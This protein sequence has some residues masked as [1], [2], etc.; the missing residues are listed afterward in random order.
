MIENT[1]FK[2][3]SLER[4]SEYELG[5]EAR[6]PCNAIPLRNI[7]HS[8]SRERIACFPQISSSFSSPF[9]NKEKVES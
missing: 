9:E 7:S 8:G 4:L 5:N 6:F 3:N 1:A 2:I